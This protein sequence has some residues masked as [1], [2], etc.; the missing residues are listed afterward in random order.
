[1][2]KFGTFL[3]ALTA[4][5]FITACSTP[6][7]QPTPTLNFTKYPV[8]NLDVSSIKVI[9]A[10][11]SPLRPPNI[12][13]LMPYSPADAMQVWIK[14]RLNTVGSDKLME[15]TIIDASVIEKDLPKTKGVKGL[16]TIDQDK[17]YDARLEV[18]IR[19]YGDAALSEADTSISITRSITIPENASANSRE[20]AYTKMIYDL[21]EMMNTKLEKNIHEYM[22]NYINYSDK[23]FSN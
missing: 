5:L 15:I 4:S 8:I 7:T 18:E 23:R 9:E 3:L 2:I 17:R 13:H 11:N 20:A 19:I 6:I 21:M 10:Y 12:E 16:L 22:N 14:D 1:M